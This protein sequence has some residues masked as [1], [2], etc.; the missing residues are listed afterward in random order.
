MPRSGTWYSFYFFEF[1]DVFLTGRKTLNTR[2]DL[3]VHHGL[4]IGKLHAHCICPGFMETCDGALREYWDQLEFYTPGYNYGYGLF[5]EGNEPA[6]SP[7]QNPDVRIVYLYRN[8]LDQIASFYRHIQAHREPSTRAYVDDRGQERVF[9]N[10]SDFLRHA[11]IQSYLKQYLTYHLMQKVAPQQ[12]LCIRYEDL[13]DDP[14]GA[15]THAVH[16]L[17]KQVESLDGLGVAIEK[18]LNASKKESLKNLERVMGASLGRDQAIP[19]ESHLRGG[20]IGK[21]QT[22][23]TSEDLDLAKEE[24]A[25]AGLNLG[26]TGL[27]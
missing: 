20:E 10:M 15:F 24:F 7:L 1:L 14:R 12:V 6:F 21:W 25:R 4:K 19:T 22:E 8:P 3:H 2:L 5:I 18:A 23:L 11:G 27:T 17:S 16:F 26:E 9:A 13:M